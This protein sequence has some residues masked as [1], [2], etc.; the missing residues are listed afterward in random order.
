MRFWLWYIFFDFRVS[1][2]NIF[3]DRS[4]PPPIISLTGK[5]LQFIFWKIRTASEACVQIHR[6]F[7]LQSP[8]G[9]AESLS[10]GVFVDSQRSWNCHLQWKLHILAAV[11]QISLLTAMMC[12]ILT[13]WRLWYDGL[14]RTQS[15]SV[16]GTHMGEQERF[17]WQQN[18]ETLFFIVLVL[19]TILHSMQY[20]SH[21]HKT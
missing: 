4:P 18:T 13:D 12:Y 9:R 15:G 14:Q 11:R 8:Y 3:S 20:S 2:F 16:R 1:V 6:Y 21:K 10:N 17:S 5:P 19:S 7:R